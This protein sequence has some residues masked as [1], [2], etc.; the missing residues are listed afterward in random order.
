[1]KKMK[2]MVALMSVGIMLMM[3]L[4]ACGGEEPKSTE[5]AEES[6][7]STKSTDGDEAV[8]STDSTDGK[9]VT[10]TI[11]R[12]TPQELDTQFE[13]EVIAEFEA[14]HPNVKI[15]YQQMAYDSYITTLQT[16][17]AS[18]DAPDIY[19]LETA[20]IEKY[21]ENGY[22]ADLSNLES[23]KNIDEADL[24]KL[25]LEG[26][27]YALG[28]TASSM[29][30]TYNKDAFEKAGITEIPET[31]DAFYDACKK[32]QEAGYAPIANGFKEGW[33]VSGNI[34]VDYITGVLAKDPEAIA[35]ACDGSKPM[36]ESELWKDEFQRFFDRYQYS[37]E[38]AFGTDW[39]NA[40]SMLAT[41]KAGMVLNGSWTIT[42]VL[43][44]N[45]DVNIG[46]F[47]LPI[48]NNAE[49]AKLLIQGPNGGW[50]A[51]QD[52]KNLDLAKEFIDY[53]SSVDVMSKEAKMCQTIT[54]VKG[55]EAAEHPAI[56]DML[57]YMEADK[58]FRQGAIEHNFPN[59]QRDI[60][61]KTLSEYLVNGNTSVDELCKQ[62]DE[63]FARI[64]Q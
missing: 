29:C 28:A 4:S 33:T 46:V 63:E 39:N 56:Q 7:E 9:K 54:V 30:V 40:C 26:K 19:L 44:L 48:S 3:G 23:V 64:A 11:L 31:L 22:A 17:L 16:K 42:S 5:S 15:D 52:S 47:A 35:G 18:G 34:Q 32:L 57:K 25:R 45:P 12:Q 13:K 61:E 55:A 41:E 8:E 49:D 10:L 14:L 27:L 21:V 6:T 2:K 60:F 58:V 50:A 51:Y 36:S 53:I 59:E 38:D 62:L 43:G 20:Y 1:M 37:N 24:A